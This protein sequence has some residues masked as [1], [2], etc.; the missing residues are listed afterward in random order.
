MISSPTL[1]QPATQQG[2]P[3]YEITPD[4]R[5][6][7]ERI[8][9][10]WLAYHG[11]LDKPLK[12]MPGQPDDN[13]MSNQMQQIVERGGE[14]LFSKELEITVEK[15]A[16]ATGQSILDKIWG[17]KEKRIPLLL[18]L[19]MNG[20]AA[21]S[22]FLR[23][24]PGKKNTYRLIVVDPSTVFVKTAPQDVETVLLWCIEY[25]DEEKINGHP[26]TVYYREEIARINQGDDI[27]DGTNDDA[28]DTDVSWSM[29]HWTRVGDRGPWHSAGPA[30]A[31]D[32]PFPPM[33]SC[34]N[35][36]KPNSFWGM[37]DLTPDLIGLNTALNLA[38]SNANRILKL[39]GSPILWASGVGDAILNIEPG[40][41]VGLPP[42]GKI[43]A[44]A[45]SNA[46]KE[47]IDFIKILFGNIDEQSGVCGVAVGRIE[48]LPRGNVSGVVVELMYMPMLKKTDKKR[49]TYGELI[50]DV[51]KALLALNNMSSDIDISLLWQQPLPA[52]DLGTV[53]AAIAKKEL[54]ISDQTLQREIGYDPVE[55]AKLSAEEDAQKLI[56]FSQGQGLPPAVPGVAP[57]PG[58]PPA[59]VP[60]Q[61]GPAAPFLGGKNA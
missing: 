4:D 49:C 34:Q 28:S 42:D 33:F 35:L 47:A 25:S 38:M 55:E 12:A 36:P 17:R 21:G 24:I 51:S 48:A 31:W 40:K 8:A 7:Q 2:Q 57:L 39:F 14:F 41:V 26:Q 58:Q 27:D 5:K 32:Y 60:G 16:A 44:V 23:I 45:L 54:N 43:G 11:E 29:Q 37:P 6:R 9:K 22:A 53:Q 46:V 19:N 61:A 56:K 10:A 20:S 13:V 3:Q 30:I 59:A 15:G 1:T 18:K 52:D 50:I